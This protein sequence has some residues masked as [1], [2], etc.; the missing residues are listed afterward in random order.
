[1]DDDVKILRMQ[2]GEDIICIFHKIST[3][4]FLICDPMV[5]IVKFKGKDSSVLMEHWLPIEIVKSNEVVV[6]P[7]DI[8]TMF[9]PK[10]SLAEYY[11]NLV[12]KLHRAIDRTKKMTHA[13]IDELDDVLEA[14]EESKF[15]SLH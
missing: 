12:E 9:D 13:E 10:E 11:N 5:L 8:I 15:Y 7:R 4:S 3:E 6:N 1:M 14:M 2:N